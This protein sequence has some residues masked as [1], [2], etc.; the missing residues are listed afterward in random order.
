MGR[1]ARR[2]RA[3]SIIQKQQH[4]AFS[5]RSRYGRRER[6]NDFVINI[7]GGILPANENMSMVKKNPVTGDT[8]APQFDVT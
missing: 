2:L 6:G 8:L 7:L 4:P 3:Y 1:L 5:L